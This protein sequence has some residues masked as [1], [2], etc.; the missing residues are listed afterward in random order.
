M[1]LLTLLSL[2]TITST[3]HDTLTA[4]TEARKWADSVAESL[5]IKEKVAQLMVLRV[6][7]WMDSAMKEQYVKRAVSSNVGGVCFFVGNSVNQ[8][9]LT[10]K[11]QQATN[12]PLLVCDDGEA[13]LGHRLTDVSPLPCQMLIG[14]LPK[15][16]DSLIYEMGALM[17]QQC[18]QMGI[19]VNF[20]P[21]VDVNTNPDNPIIGTRSIGQDPKMVAHKATL[22]MHGM[23][24]GGVMA[25]AKHFPG[26]GDTEKDSHFTLP[27]VNHSAKEI[28]A[29]NMLP[30]RTLAEEGVGGMMVAHLHIPSMDSRPGMPT[31]LSERVVQC[32]LR[33]SIGYNGLIFTDGIDMQAI[34]QHYG[35]GISDLMALKAGCD[36]VLLP[37]DLETSIDVVSQAAESDT[38]VCALIDSLCRRVLAAKYQLVKQALPT[39]SIRP[40]DERLNRKADSLT[41]RMAL[42]AVTLLRDDDVIADYDARCFDITTPA[43]I[44]LLNATLDT[45]SDTVPLFITIYSTPYDLNK[46][47]ARLDTLHN[48]MSIIVA[49]QNL[50]QVRR[51][52]DTLVARYRNNPQDVFRGKLPVDAGGYLKG[53]AF[54]PH[55]ETNGLPASLAR[56]IDSIA[57]RGIALHAYPGCQIVVAHRGKIVYE[58]SYGYLSYDSLRPVTH[59]TMYDIASVTKVAATTLAIMRLTEEGRIRLDEPLSHYLPYLE[60]SN[61]KDITFRQVLSHYARLQ[62]GVAGWTNIRKI[63]PEALYHDTLPDCSE[64]VYKLIAGSKL[65]DEKKYVYSDLSL[66]LMGDVVRRVSG[67]ALD[68]YVDSCFYRPMGLRRTT[69]NPLLKGYAREE[70]APT[71]VDT[72][73][74]GG[75][76]CGT[77]HDPNAASMGGVAGHAG[78]FTTA[79][80]L[81]QICLMLYNG[82]VMDGKCFLSDSIIN[83][84]NHRYY[85]GEGVRRGLGFDKPLFQPTRESH[86]A[87]DC[88][89]SSYGHTGFTGTMIWI[90][91]DAELVYVFLSNRVH[92]DAHPNRLASLNIRTDIQHLL[93]ELNRRK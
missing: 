19:H 4:T 37:P 70:I 63:N 9:S 74:R 5:T 17:A 7:V 69:F 10:Q 21:V 54:D 16:D 68:R 2:L 39:D 81:A 71:E 22:L 76:V 40:I 73:L 42:D 25:V 52:V 92:P 72:Q 56:R 47:R 48:P 13:G 61:K 41:Y 51:A 28:K 67:V 27:V 90:D 38:T 60:Q 93:Y 15:E 89:Q 32:W 24:D 35:N 84:F 91:P 30:F 18:R 57:N 82:G 62:S 64:D 86:T 46:L 87:V 14:A 8:V 75:T 23:Q 58:H 49:Y 50:P 55:K 80:E 31:S 66:I 6:P 12:L 77:V 65:L 1:L 45:L 85:G 59:N 88:T 33:D 29:V 26:H 44:R 53:Y 3:P 11:L 20:A 83:I 79:E 36:V 78:L 34:M 43:S